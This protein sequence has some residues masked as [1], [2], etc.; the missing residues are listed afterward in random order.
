MSAALT[1]AAADFDRIV[2]DGSRQRPV[3]VDF[4]APWCA[5][6][7]ALAPI[8]DK[9]AA[10]F[11]G[12]FTLAKV[13]T[14]EAP[15]VAGRYGI[16][17]IP[18]CKLFVD[19][20]VVDEFVGVLPEGQLREFLA[21]ALPS[22]AAPFV[23]SAMGRLAAGDAQGALADLDRGAAIDAAD[24]DLLLTRI[25]ALVALGRVA[26]AQAGVETLESPQR[27]RARPVRDERRLASLKARVALAGS[28]AGDLDALARAAATS[29]ADCAAKLAYAQAL[30]ARS[31][32]EAAL[33]EY[34]AI[35]AADRAF[36]DDAG[37]KGMLTIF[38]ALGNDGDLVRRYRRE[39][40]SILNR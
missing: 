1:V 10:E 6:C 27:E 40:A 19:G 4:W 36:G 16:R 21:G 13:N 37:R 25:E 12:R 39:L 8:L 23:A 38:A 34:L 24:E 5:P 32:Y 11:A 22:A 26:D 29:P 2:L 15:D 35:V 7:R 28:A 9:L 17:S 20:A 30:A 3:L 18:S 33:R 31:D 14:D